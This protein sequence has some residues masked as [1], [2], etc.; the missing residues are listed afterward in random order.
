MI[1]LATLRRAREECVDGG[2]EYDEFAR[3]AY[4][5]WLGLLD[6]LAAHRK[7]E[8]ALVDRIAAL[9]AEAVKSSHASARRSEA[10]RCLNMVRV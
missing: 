3:L 5:E 4:R 1:D 8:A 2:A 7:V 6:E 9:D 10:I